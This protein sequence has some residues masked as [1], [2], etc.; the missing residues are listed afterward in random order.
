MIAL[1]NTLTVPAVTITVMIAN[2]MKFTGR[3]RKLPAFIAF[4]SR[5]EAREIAEVEQQR[6]EIGHDQ[7]RGVRHMPQWPTV[8]AGGLSC[9]DRLEIPVC[10]RIQIASAN[11]TT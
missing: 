3:P 8:R 10:D 9:N 4:S 1:P 2:T 11:I 5:A 7:H 6:R